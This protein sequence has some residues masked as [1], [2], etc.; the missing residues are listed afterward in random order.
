MML[1]RYRWV[2]FGIGVTLLATVGFVALRTTVAT[3]RPHDVLAAT[4]SKGGASDAEKPAW[5]GLSVVHSRIAFSGDA[6]SAT[7][8]GFPE[9]N[10]GAGILVDVDTGRILWQLNDHAPL[11]PASTIKMLTALVVLDNFSP[12]RSITATP[13]ALN[14]AWDETK[15]GLKTGMT[16]SMRE[17]LTAMLMVSANDAAMAL[18][19]DTVGLQRFVAAMNAQVAAL[20]LHDTS[21]S[22]PV[23]LDDPG[24]R[25]SAYD[26]AV[27]AATVSDRFSLFRNIVA[28]KVASIPASANHP[29]FWL[30]NVN[31]LFKKYAPAV[32]IKPGWTGDAGACEVGM[33]VRDGHRLIS[34]L[35]HGTLVYTASARLLDWGFSREGL[36][37]LLPPPPSPPATR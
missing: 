8:A 14:Q 19:V 25:A 34:V 9:I 12:D 1:R 31:G 33:A 22:S 3:G 36:P 30:D 24:M 27:I 21:V 17:L 15:M 35:M 4:V 6:V 26:L 20:G 13:D 23:G 11:P 10:A 32:G 16:L 7:P 5:H 2:A 18:A 28:T 29:V 37:A